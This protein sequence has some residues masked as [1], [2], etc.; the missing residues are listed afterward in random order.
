M[1]LG[2]TAA[3]RVRLNRA[4][5]GMSQV[6]PDPVEQAR[7]YGAETKCARWREQLVCSQC[8]GRQVD[9]VVTGE[10][11]LSMELVSL[12]HVVLRL[13]AAFPWS[14]KSYEAPH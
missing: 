1:T 5:P 3:A 6:Q 8:G 11:R 14:L 2:N 13:P 7:R 9:M 4:V 10:C 12:G